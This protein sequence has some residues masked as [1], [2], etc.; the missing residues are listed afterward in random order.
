MALHIRRAVIVCVLA[1]LMVPLSGCWVFSVYPLA[2]SDDELVFDKLLAGNWWNQQNRCSVSFSRFPDERTYRVV[3]TTGKDASES[4]WLD[5]GSSASFQGT[6]VE[7]GGAR[8][9]DVLPAD[10]PLQNHM[11]LAHSFYRLKVDVNSLS[12]TP[13]NYNF[14]E[15]LMKQEKL[16]GVQRS[17]EVMALTANTKELREFIR[18]NATSEDLWDTTRKLDFQRRFDGQ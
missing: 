14:L 7:L 15:G 5:K 11:V 3:Y 10:L 17:D 13:M 2:S 6:V 4:C 9:L 8:F 1:A 18:Q 16:R 12:L